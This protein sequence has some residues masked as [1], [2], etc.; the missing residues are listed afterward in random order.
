MD[1]G[2]LE[3]EMVPRCMGG[4]AGE[5]KEVVF[6]SVWRG[7]SM[8]RRERAGWIEEGRLVDRLVRLMT[9]SEED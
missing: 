4:R 2:P 3:D 5:G 8:G 6:R 9:S 1:G 7:G